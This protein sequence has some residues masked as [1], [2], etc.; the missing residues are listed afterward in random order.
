MVSLTE[1]ELLRY[2]RQ[3]SLPQV[4][5]NGQ[6]QLKN[7]SV[8]CIGAGGIGSPALL[9][10]TAAGIGT[11]GI[12]DDD[13]VELSNLQRQILY[14]TED[15]G[16]KKVTA[17]KQQLLAINPHLQIHT[18]AERLNPGNAFDV[19]PHYQI[20]I[21]G[22]DNYATR[23]L[24]SD[25]C[26]ISKITLISASLFQFSGQLLTFYYGQKDTA[27]YRCLYPTPPPPGLMQ[28]CADAGII[29]S[30]AGIL[31]TM[32]A[33]QAIKVLLNTQPHDKNK[34]F[35]FNGLTLE[36]E[37]YSFSKKADCVLCAKETPF[38]KLPRSE[39]PFCSHKKI[40]EI[41]VKQLAAYQTQNKK[42]LLID[43]RSSLERTFGY[44]PD[45]IHIPMENI[46]QIDPAKTEFQNKDAIVLYCK[47]GL[48]S[49]HAA[50]ILQEIGLENIYNLAGGIIDWK[51]QSFA[52]TQK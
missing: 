46:T 23:Y 45:S 14:A 7:A 42:M 17:A 40:K 25:V 4:G 26:Q 32:A 47:S 20:V 15:C 8:L 50:K 9:Y 51:N 31:G 11:I 5:V 48:R 21:D 37:K 39:A 3:I 24:A 27:C 35:I 44:I 33:T 49:A 36:L 52:I 18:Y 34:L 43:V 6:E 28:N 1:D 2:R 22:S 13:V 30:V 19:I 16:Q 10:L 38:E 41:S 12:V 29:G